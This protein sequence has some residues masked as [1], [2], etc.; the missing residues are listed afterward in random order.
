MKHPCG[1][2]MRDMTPLRLE[3]LKGIPQSTRESILKMRPA[4]T[5]IVGWLPT[6]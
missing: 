2:R 1:K 4:T 6:K 5:L 3:D